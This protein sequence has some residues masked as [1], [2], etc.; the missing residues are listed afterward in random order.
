MAGPV[1]PSQRAH[2]QP[3]Y[4]EVADSK[5]EHGPAPQRL[6]A[7]VILPERCA[8]WKKL[9]LFFDS[10]G[11]EGYAYGRKEYRDMSVE[12]G[13]AQAYAAWAIFMTLM[14]EPYNFPPPTSTSAGITPLLSGHL[15]QVELL[16]NEERASFRSSLSDIQACSRRLLRDWWEGAYQHPSI[17]GFARSFVAASG[18]LNLHHLNRN[19]PLYHENLFSLFDAEFNPAMY[20]T[21]TSRGMSG[22]RRLA[23]DHAIAQHAA[24][25]LYLKLSPQERFEVDDLRGPKYLEP[26]YDICPWL[27]S[28]TKRSGDPDRLP[29]YLWDRVETRTV[30][31]QELLDGGYHVSYTCINHTWGR[32]QKL[33]PPVYVCGVD[34]W[35]VPENEIFEVKELPKILAGAPVSTRFV[36]FDLICIPQDIHNRLYLIEVSRQAIIFQRANSCI[37]WLNTVDSWRSTEAAVRWLCLNYMHRGSQKGYYDTEAPL[38]QAE[39]EANT[40]IELIV[41]SQTFTPWFSSL[42]TLQEACLCPNIIL[43]DKQWQA[44]SIVPGYVV[45]L[46]HLTTLYSINQ[47]AYFPDRLPSTDWPLGPAQFSW[48]QRVVFGTQNRA[49]RTSIMAQGQT[50]KCRDRRAEAIMSVLGV[51]DWHESYVKEHGKPPPDTDLVLGTYPLVF[52]REAAAKMGSLFYMSTQPSVRMSGLD[53]VSGSMMPFGPPGHENMT[54]VPGLDEDW[55]HDSIDHPS[56][57]EWEI[58][59]DGS[60]KIFEVAILRS[61]ERHYDEPLEV[62]LNIASQEGGNEVLATALQAWLKLVPAGEVRVAISLCKMSYVHSGLIL[63]GVHMSESDEMVLRSIGSWD[64]R[65]DIDFPPGEKVNFTVV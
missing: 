7:S 60:V 42:W 63:E 34:D 29:F 45:T 48:I 44:L 26:A 9:E 30:K 3:G 27:V 64:T 6:E 31:V 28:D 14:A 18:Q 21:G 47:E 1:Q 50:R 65:E 36:W 39:H 40:K 17:S 56:L 19:A 53:Q 13:W 5:G 51:T 25:L 54:L 41:D 22:N 61:S 62:I 15:E 58:R 16:Q 20:R 8:L 49:T 46:N 37:A 57:A 55:Y 52:V 33:T 43:C 23:Y 11:M 24:Y 10:I 35:M 12:E 4:W 32:W 38:L 59:S 2:W